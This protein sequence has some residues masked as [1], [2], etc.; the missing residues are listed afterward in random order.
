MKLRQVEIQNFRGIQELCWNVAGDFVCLIGPGD[1]TK[2]TILDAIELALSPRWNVTFYD[3]DFYNAVTSDPIILTVSVGDLPEAFK[4]DLKFGYSSR[5]WTPEGTLRDEPSHGDELVLSIRLRVDETLEPSWTVFNDRNPKGVRISAQDR[6]K[7]GCTRLGDYVDRHFSWGR[8]TVLSKLTSEPEK[9]TGVLADAS[10][11]ARAAVAGLEPASIQSLHKASKD[12]KEAAAVLG[13]NI[14]DDLRPQLDAHSVSVGAGGLSLHNDEIPMRMA[15]L[16]TRR[17]TAIAM[18]R[19]VAKQAG[20]TLIDE[21]ENA[22]EPHRLRHLLRALRDDDVRGHVIATTHSA[23]TVGELGVRELRVVRSNA[24]TTEVLKLD[25]SLQPLVCNASEAFLAHKVLV[26]E[27]RTEL[28]FCRGLDAWWTEKGQSF[29]LSGIALVDGGGTEAPT[30][31]IGFA[32]LGYEVALF[33]DADRPLNPDKATLLAKN[34]CVV[35]WQENKALEDQI[36][37]DLPWSG[38]AKAVQLAMDEWGDDGVTAAVNARLESTKKVSGSPE[39]WLDQDTDEGALRTAIAVAAK[40]H[41]K[42]WFKRVNLA[43]DLAGIVVGH[44]AE[45]VGKDLHKNILV[46]KKWAHG[47]G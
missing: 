35:Q 40:N 30:R 20:L 36:I 23:V 41:Q 27:G 1:S 2:S 24:G 33:V 22:L 44:W 14:G 17:L 10:R 11:K 29:G 7:L 9:L 19:E 34:I 5:G 38:V 26:C 12:A 42:G 45:I 3:T 31:S 28:G 4:S 16:G 32:D 47:N 15:G 13:A 39:D 21:V 25:E 43:Q 37:E 6:D 8:G 18:Q 46:L